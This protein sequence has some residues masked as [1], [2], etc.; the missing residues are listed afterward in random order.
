[1]RCI[2]DNGLTAT[3]QSLCFADDC[4][5][6]D[7]ATEQCNLT[8]LARVF[9]YPGYILIDRQGKILYRNDKGGIKDI[10]K[11]LQEMGLY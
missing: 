1:M 8:T 10:V 9:S 6:G 3:I 4:S 7:A 2:Q 5:E 11:R